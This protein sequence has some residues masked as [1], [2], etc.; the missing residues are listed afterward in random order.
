M[1]AMPRFAIIVVLL[2]AAPLALADSCD[3]PCSSTQTCQ[4]VFNSAA[5]ECTE[6]TSEASSACDPACAAVEVCKQVFNSDAYECVAADTGAVSAPAPDAYPTNATGT[7]SPVTATDSPAAAFSSGGGSGLSG[8]PG[9][10]LGDMRAASSRQ[11]L[12]RRNLRHLGIE[13]LASTVLLA[14]MGFQPAARARLIAQLPG[15]CHCSHC[16]HKHFAHSAR[17]NSFAPD[18]L[19]TGLIDCIY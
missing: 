14:S 6:D 17:C 13:S 19:D 2:A 3:P 5:Y 1:H 10:A 4:Q 16:R 18:A 15:D 11:S 12:R 9:L 7:A 8:G